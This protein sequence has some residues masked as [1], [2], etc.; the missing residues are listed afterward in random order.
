M[1]YIVYS[2]YIY[3]SGKKKNLDFYCY[4]HYLFIFLNSKMCYFYLHRF[5]MMELQKEREKRVAR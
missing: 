2:Y 3:A 5:V 1:Y 4:Y